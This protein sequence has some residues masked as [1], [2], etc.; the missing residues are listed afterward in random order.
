MPK[1]IINSKSILTDI[2]AGLS[3][4]ALREKY[5]LNPKCLD[6][7]FRKLLQNGMISRVELAARH[8]DYYK[9]IEVTVT[10]SDLGF[11]TAE[12]VCEADPAA[13]KFMFSGHVECVDILDYIQFVLTDGRRAV[14]D[15]HALTGSKCRL[16]IEAGQ[17]LHA[18]SDDKEGAEAFYQCTQY[19]GG[20]FSH[21]V[22]MEP[23]HISIKEPG[24]YL[25][26]EAAR[27]RDEANSWAS[28][29]A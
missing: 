24:T 22:W 7:V 20:K 23:K 8:D 11:E 27:R 9:D 14:L 17:V 13:S 6:K 5:D 19:R 28:A 21:L 1:I 3:D 18:E 15:V 29:T 26:L 25:L 4:I 10:D 2:R 16:Y 12:V